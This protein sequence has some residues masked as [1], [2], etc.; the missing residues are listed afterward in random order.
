MAQDAPAPTTSPY[1]APAPAQENAPGKL[2]DVPVPTVPS[3]P[4][5]AKPAP[6]KPLHP[7]GP[8]AQPIPA[9]QAIK[10]VVNPDPLSGLPEAQRN[11]YASLQTMLAQYGLASLAPTLLGY[12][13]KGYDGDSLTYLLSQTPEYKQ[14]FAGNDARAKA[15]LAPLSPAEYLATERSYRQVMQAAGLPANF[16]DQPSDYQTLIGA[17]ISP[18]ELKDRADNAFRFAQNVDPNSTAGQ[19]KAA[20]QSYYGVTDSH[21]AAYF[22]DP[23]QSEAIL[24]RQVRSAEIG[25]S[26]SANGLNI[27]QVKAEAYADQGVTYAQAQQGAAQAGLIKDDALAAAQRFHSDFSQSDLTDAAIGGLASAQRKQK[28]LADSEAALFAG[29]AAQITQTSTN[30][31]GAY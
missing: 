22:L 10:Q 8:K 17:D 29:N 30:M 31:G 28:Q 12:V 14:R 13:Q 3:A 4:F 27:N 6:P 21:V 24:D 26:A 9:D 11:A 1:I 7:V 19:A 2:A 25:G 15:G 20:L 23:K 16:Y 5:T 18:T